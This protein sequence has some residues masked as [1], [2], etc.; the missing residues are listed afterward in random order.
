MGSF[1]SILAHALLA[2]AIEN[3]SSAEPPDRIGQP[4]LEPCGSGGWCAW[5]GMRKA[6]DVLK[7][8]SHRPLSDLFYHIY[9]MFLIH[10]TRQSIYSD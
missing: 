8:H 9:E 1:A 7:W 4:C 5:C 2:V 10:I 6:E 3:H